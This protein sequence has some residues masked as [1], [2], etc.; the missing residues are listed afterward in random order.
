MTAKIECKHWYNE[1]TDDEPPVWYCRDCS[2]KLTRIEY[3]QGSLSIG[4]LKGEFQSDADTF[5]VAEAISRAIG[6]SVRIIGLTYSYSEGATP[7]V[8]LGHGSDTLPATLDVY[9]TY[10]YEPTGDFLPDPSP[11]AED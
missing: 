7:T 5:D 9:R 3:W 4:I 8:L 10:R 1:R 11:V 2:V 6:S